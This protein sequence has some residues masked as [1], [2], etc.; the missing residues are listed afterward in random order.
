MKAVIQQ[1]TFENLLKRGT[2]SALAEEAQGDSTNLSPLIKSVKITIDANNLTIESATNLTSIRVSIPSTKENGIEVKEEGVAVVAAKELV[3]WVSKQTSSKIGLSVTKLAVPE[4]VEVE[5]ADMEAMSK[6]AVRKT[7]DLKI[8]S[9]DNTSTGSKWSLDSYDPDQLPKSIKASGKKKELFTVSPKKIADAVGGIIFSSQSKDYQHIFDSLV[10][11]KVG[12]DIYIGASDQKRCAVYKLTD[13]L[14]KIGEY[15]EEDGSK[16][17]IPASNLQ[18]VIKNSDEAKDLT[19]S[20]D[21]ERHALF[22][23]Q[24]NMIAR[25]A[26][27]EKNIYTKFPSLSNLIKKPYDEL[28]IMP[29][30]T[31]ARCLLTVAMV[32]KESALFVFNVA[33]SELIAY[34]ASD[35]GKSPIKSTCPVEK[36]TKDGKYIW[37]VQHVMDMMKATKDSNITFMIPSDANSF[38]VVSSSDPN[39]QFYGMNI[40]NAKYASVNV[41]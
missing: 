8:S 15:F 36:L 18:D 11:Q 33:K 13:Q 32:N 5:G 19:F 25:L 20:Y 14:V 40:D 3:D 26:I 35:S 27:P 17:L 6:D 7:A 39:V 1:E 22:V 2:M 38:K 16:I 41:D 29:K 30:A 31:L 10:F 4:T 24:E 12:K 9:K 21:E 37:S 28:G 34:A 23:E